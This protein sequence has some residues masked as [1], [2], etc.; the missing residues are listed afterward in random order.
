MSEM[1]SFGI[2]MGIGGAFL[3]T[4][5]VIFAF[6]LILNSKLGKGLF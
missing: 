4:A 1:M 5:A 3:F 6:V 2:V